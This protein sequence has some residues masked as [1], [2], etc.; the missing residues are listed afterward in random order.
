[1][2][3]QCPLRGF[4]NCKGLVCALWD[5]KRKC[6]GLITQPPIDAE[7]LKYWMSWQLADIDERRHD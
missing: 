6:C 7:D 2:F 1:M 4:N 3:S 5:N